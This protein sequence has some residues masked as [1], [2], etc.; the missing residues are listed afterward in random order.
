MGAETF[1][2]EEHNAVILFPES[3]QKTV[4]SNPFYFGHSLRKV[5]ALKRF[6]ADPA[7]TSRLKGDVQGE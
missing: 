3:E 5:A 7:G 4:P 1:D 2:Y 6:G